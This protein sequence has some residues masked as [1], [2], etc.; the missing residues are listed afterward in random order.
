MTTPAEGHWRLAS[1]YRKRARELRQKLLQTFDVVL[2]DEWPLPLNEA[3][4]LREILEN[5]DDPANAEKFKTIIRGYLPQMEEAQSRLDRLMQTVEDREVRRSLEWQRLKWT[6]TLH[7]LRML[8]ALHPL[9]AEYE[10]SA[11]A[12]RDVGDGL[13]GTGQ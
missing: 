2:D 12:M 4:L 7:L 3:N 8:R 5:W 9:V 1:N 11:K 10:A 6:Q 13:A